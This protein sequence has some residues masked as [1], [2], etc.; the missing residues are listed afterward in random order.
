MK[1]FTTANCDRIDSSYIRANRRQL[2]PPH[3]NRKV[4][5]AIKTATAEENIV[6][7]YVWQSSAVGGA[8]ILWKCP[9]CSRGAGN[10]YRPPGAEGFRCRRCWKLAYPSQNRPRRTRLSDKE[11]RLQNALT[12]DSLPPQRWMS[13]YRELEVVKASIQ[14]QKE[15]LSS[16]VKARTAVRLA[17]MSH[18][19]RRRGRPSKR[20]HRENSRAKKQMTML[21]YDLLCDEWVERPRRPVGRPKSKRRYERRTC[22]SKIRLLSPTEAYCPKCRERRTSLDPQPRRMK[23]DRSALVGTCPTCGTT[24][25]RIVS[26]AVFHA[27]VDV[28]D[29]ADNSS[30]NR[31]SSSCCT[32]STP[33]TESEIPAYHPKRPPR[34]GSQ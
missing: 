32:R 30:P 24:V 34:K 29:N 7:D 2:A 25:W 8:R 23:N 26:Q 27:F 17:A 20:W 18:I 12:V 19:S 13:L 21:Q 11:R 33:P 15:A 4:A 6:L 3:G 16:I 31:E 14:D 10:L 1:R 5:V 22:D 28:A 9:G